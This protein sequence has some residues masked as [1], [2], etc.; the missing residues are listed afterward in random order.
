MNA[1]SIGIALAICAAVA[2]NASYLMQHAGSST[3]AGDRRSPAAGDARPAAAQAHLGRRRRRRRHRL[4]AAHRRAARSAAL[5][6]SGLRRRRA[7]THRAHGGDRPAPAPR[8]RRDA[9]RGCDGRRTGP[10]FD[11]TGRR[12]PSRQL[13]AVGAGCAR[14]RSWQAEPRC[15]PRS[16]RAGTG[17]WR[18]AQPAGCCTARRTWGSRA[19]PG[20]TASAPSWPRPGCTP[21]SPARPARS[22]PFSAG[23][24]R[25]GRSP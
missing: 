25:R 16:R 3:A 18:S 10:S 14:S 2:L 19:S 24:N 15:W 6:G 8:A 5:T 23:C 11:R 12:W 17:R 9:G 22:S 20:C 21:R 13:L 4:G 7:R 1:T